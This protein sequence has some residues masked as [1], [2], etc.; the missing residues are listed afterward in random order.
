[1]GHS[2]GALLHALIGSRYP[3]A[4]AGNVLMSYNN[5]PATGRLGV[6]GWSVCW[7]LISKNARTPVGGVGL[8]NVPHPLPGCCPDLQ[9][10]YCCCTALCRLDPAAVAAD[11]ALPPAA[12]TF[13]CLLGL[14]L[15]DSI[16]LLSPLIAPNLR[17][18]GPILSQLATSPLRSGVEQWID[19]LK[20]AGCGSQLNDWT[21]VRGSHVGKR[22]CAAML[23]AHQ[24]LPRRIGGCA[25]S[26]L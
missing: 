22:T 7:L 2:L 8:G 13:N 24:P 1:M 20:G 17:A 4:S 19:L 14:L 15:A 25:A 12:F 21:V 23:P 11:R 9:R 3:I 26:A 6:Q 18:L 16:P 10:I 5:R